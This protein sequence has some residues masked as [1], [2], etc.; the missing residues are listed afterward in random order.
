[1][2]SRQRRGDAGDVGPQVW[3]ATGGA[4]LC[5]EFSCPLRGR[6]GRI[7]LRHRDRR[8]Q[9]RELCCQGKASDV[10]RARQATSIRCGGSAVRPRRRGESTPWHRGIRSRSTTRWRR[11]SP[12][13]EGAWRPSVASLSG[14]DLATARMPRPVRAQLAF[15]RRTPAVGEDVRG[16]RGGCV[17]PPVRP[18]EDS[19]ARRRVSTGSWC[20]R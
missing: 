6:A 17:L 10:A 14:C 1:M 12:S 5:F 3:R 2:T 8:T 9:D 7:K 4:M 13:R 11:F 20:A 16:W 19:H 15:S 18:G